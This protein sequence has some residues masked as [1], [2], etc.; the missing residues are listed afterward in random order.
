MVAVMEMLEDSYLNGAVSSERYTDT[1]KRL[2]AAYDM[3]KKAAMD[4][5]ALVSV[6]DFIKE[7]K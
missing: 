1:Y 7:Y 5:G 6:E 3:A 4:T 2:S